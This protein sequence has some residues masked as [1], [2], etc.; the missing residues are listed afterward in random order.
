MIYKI[1]Y[2]SVSMKKILVISLHAD[3]E[4][5]GAGGCL[6]RDNQTDYALSDYGFVPNFYV[7]ISQ[8][9]DE[10]IS[11]MTTY[12]NEVKESPFPGNV[13]AIKGLTKYRGAACNVEYAEAF[14]IIKQI[15][16]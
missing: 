16:R 6:F 3:D 5:L 2:A 8:Y 15:E 9:I 12:K 7:D 1:G 13:D 11:I 4:T 14:R 10:K